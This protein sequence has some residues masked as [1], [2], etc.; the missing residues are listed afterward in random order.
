VKWER[1]IS[2]VGRLGREIETRKDRTKAEK[3]KKIPGK[4]WR[5]MIE[6]MLDRHHGQSIV[7]FMLFFDTFRTGVWC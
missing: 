5:G 1:A 4:R 2:T 7:Q 3:R 6:K